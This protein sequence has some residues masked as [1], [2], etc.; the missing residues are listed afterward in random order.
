MFGPGFE[1]R[2]LHKHS[3]SGSFNS[4]TVLVSTGTF[5]LINKKD[6]YEK[7]CNTYF[8]STSAFNYEGS[9]KLRT[10]QLSAG[11]D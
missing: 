2:R 8:I 5:Y 1:S 6:H 11:Y 3:G 4:S 9:T 7:N 10:G